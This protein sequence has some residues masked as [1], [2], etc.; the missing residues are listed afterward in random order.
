MTLT[1]PSTIAIDG[2]AG[3]GKSS[4]SFAVAQ[5]INYLFVDTGAFYRAVTFLALEQALDL[6]D[7]A[8][9]VALCEQTHFDMT[10]DRKDD[11]RQFTFLANERD[12]TQD[13]NT[14]QVDKAVSIV[15]ATPEVRASVLEAQRL[16]AKKGRVIMAG[17]D[18]GTVVL[19]NADLKI[20]IDASLEKR[21]E[22]RHKQRRDNG[23]QADYEAILANLRE[24]DRLDSSRDTAP[25]LQADDAIKL[26]TSDLTFDATIEAA[27]TLIANWTPSAT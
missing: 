27:Y 15:A 4:V 12:I 2:P 3:S 14:P 13:L 20:Y 17:R 9:L 23:E 6:H 26:D 16:L 18:I 1:L 10:P 11:G 5:R 24:R 19:P 8:Q 22:R 25:L 21:A 7:A